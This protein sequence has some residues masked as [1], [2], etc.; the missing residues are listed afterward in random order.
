MAAVRGQEL[1]VNGGLE[2]FNKCPKGPAVKR[3]KV[4][5][6]VRSAQGDPDLYAVCSAPFGVPGNWSGRQAAWEGEAYAGLVLTTDM[7]NE[8][9]AREFI[10][11][12]LK[13]P[14][15]SGRRYRLTFRV[16]PAEH[17]GY[18][19]DRVAALFSE[20]DHTAKG[21]SPALRERADVQNTPGRL[22][23]DTTGWTTVTGI[24]NAKGGERYVLIGNF[25]TCNASTRVRMDASKKASMER[26]AATRMDPDEGRGAWRGGMGHVAYVYL[27]GVSLVPDSTSPERINTLT[28]E[29]ACAAEVPRAIGP[30]L[31]ADPG[32][33]RNLHPT[34][35]SWRNASDGTPDLFDGETGLY[36]YSDGYPDNREY[37]R[38]P[39][40]E[41]LS[42]CSTYRVSLDVR[43]NPSYA[44]AVDAIGVA[45]T[46]TFTT[47]RDRLRIELPWAWR[48]P[49]GAL[50]AQSDRAMTL[51]GTFTPQVCARHLLVG[52]FS[53]DCATTIVQVGPDGNG[54]FA[55]SFVDNVH[56]AAVSSVP[57]CVDPC[58]ASL[59]VSEATSANASEWPDR[60]V[61]HFDTDSDLPLELDAG[62]LDRL[63]A[64][65]N[66]DRSMRLHITGH[67]DDSGT[68]ARNQRLAL[69]R[70]DR[71]RDLLVQRGAPAD[72]I[73]TSSAGSGHPIADNTSPEGRAMNR[74]VEVE[75]L[76]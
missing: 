23:N 27:D 65:L 1:V 12:P 57:G 61:L 39:L 36:L 71:L 32:F 35:D 48:S 45:V 16:S 18:V 9:A 4:D 15:E 8:C 5:G 67:A 54:P 70:A 60:I 64:T 38:I 68:P 20:V 69:A 17:S 47:R 19:T 49:P 37:I 58:P 46:D 31:I 14:L 10:Q 25:H 76:R 42:P 66:A 59:S 74:R 29:L 52:N 62:A 33:D 24:H 21:L 2:T 28:T 40:A 50:M 22:L 75:V 6:K 72:S 34:P 30:E 41:P 53:A 26:K 3:L 51:C 44:F 55:Y 73:V 56:L 7:P 63:A 43:R 13:A 11:F